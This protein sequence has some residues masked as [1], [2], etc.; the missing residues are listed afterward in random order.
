MI[1]YIIF[2]PFILIKFVYIILN[3]NLEKYF[4]VTKIVTFI[5]D[6]GM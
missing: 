4:H 1:N 5:N 6:C 3:T 2:I